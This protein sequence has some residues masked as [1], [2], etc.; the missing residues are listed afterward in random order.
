MECCSC[1]CPPDP[2]SEELLSPRERKSDGSSER[3]RG[4]TDCFCLLVFSATLLGASIIARA[5]FR[6]GDPE[7]LT[8]GVDYTGALCGLGE[9]AARC[10]VFFFSHGD[11]I[12]SPL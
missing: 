5:A 9:H 1:C 10:V 6:V 8:N 3:S 12:S 7:R 4:C 11:N 2:Q